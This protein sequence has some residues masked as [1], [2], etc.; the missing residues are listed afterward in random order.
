MYYLSG[1]LA[2]VGWPRLGRVL[3]AVFAVCCVGGALGGGNMFQANQAF[4]QVVNAT[5]GA[6]S[7]LVGRGWL[8]G[9]LLAALVGA[10][11]IGGIKSIARVTEKLVPLMAA[12]YLG[13][14]LVILVMHA[15]EVIPALGLIWQGAL[16]GEGAVGGVMGALIQGFRRAAFSNEAGI[17]SAAIAHSA[18]RTRESFSEGYVALLEPFIDTVVICT[19][20]ALVIIVTGVRQPD[21]IG[22]ELTSTAFA[23][24][25][26]WF[27]V[28]LAVCVL[29]FAFSTMISWSYYG[30][31]AWTYLVGH[32]RAQEL[33]FKL[34]FCVCVVV[35]ASMHLGPVI[36]FSDSMVF[37]MAIPNVMGLYLLMPLL[38]RELTSY[39]KRLASGEI[40]AL[41]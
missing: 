26:P 41:W 40:R 17:G 20:T 2:H 6:A 8:F 9:L 21:L 30:L 28:V 12:L 16:T 24:G 23:T 19:I 27:P 38:R 37:L 5:G 11:I 39:R 35:G 22:V 31:K 4:H 7:P 34:F 29:L 36:D 1:G 10:V 3:A 32:S 18:A 14:G 13:A 33:T 25:L 15:R